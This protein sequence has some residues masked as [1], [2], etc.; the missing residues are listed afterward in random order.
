MPLREVS[1]NIQPSHLLKY[2]SALYQRTVTRQ[3][4]EIKPPEG[5]GSAGRTNMRRSSIRQIRWWGPAMF[6]D[7]QM[8]GT[9]PGIHVPSLILSWCKDILRASYFEVALRGDK[10]AVRD[11]MAQNVWKKLWASP[12]W[13]AIHDWARFK[14]FLLKITHKRNTS[15]EK[16]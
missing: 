6:C 8:L 13:A 12:K 10:Q 11:W 1:E 9:W 2:A 15:A 7:A 14:V 4:E 5:I 3:F 16:T